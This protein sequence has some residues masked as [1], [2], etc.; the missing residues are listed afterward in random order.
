MGIRDL[1]NFLEHNF[2]KSVQGKG[3]MA[4]P[5]TAN[6][7]VNSQNFV[8]PADGTAAEAKRLANEPIT[9]GSDLYY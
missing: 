4:Y 7:S 1:F 8:D 5:E 3:K 6:S 9:E 2:S